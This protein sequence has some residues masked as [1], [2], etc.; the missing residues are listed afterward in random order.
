MKIKD[1][2]ERSDIAGFEDV[3]RGRESRKVGNSRWK[4]QRNEIPP[5]VS[6]GMQSCPPLGFSLVRPMVDF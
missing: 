2:S 5:K 1:W 3:R 6:D 4:R